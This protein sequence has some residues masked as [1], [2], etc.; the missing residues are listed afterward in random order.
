MNEL[1][2]FLILIGALTVLLGLLLMVIGKIPL[3][4][5]LPGDIIIEK[6]NFVLYLPIG[7]S[8]LLS[9]LLSLILYFLGRR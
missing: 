5:R 6:R 1:G 9:I 8:I 3:I 4:G 7:T 2:K